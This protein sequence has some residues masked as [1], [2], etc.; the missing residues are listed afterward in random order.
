MPTENRFGIANYCAASKSS[1]TPPVTRNSAAAAFILHPSLPRLPVAEDAT[2]EPLFFKHKP[3]TPKYETKNHPPRS[4]HH[5]A[6]PLLEHLR[7]GMRR[8]G[9]LPVTIITGDFFKIISE[10]EG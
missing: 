9:L 1:H 6:D 2:S 5:P 10:D 3:T 4:R 8:R 7:A